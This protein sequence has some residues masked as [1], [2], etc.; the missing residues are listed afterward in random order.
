LCF[1]LRCLDKAKLIAL[2]M[3]DQALGQRGGNERAQG[4]HTSPAWYFGLS[5]LTAGPRHLWPLWPLYYFFFF[6]PF[7]LSFFL[8][9]LA[10]ILTSFQ[11][12][13]W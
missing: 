8:P 9:F 11:A 7:F 2:D 1:F 13:D 4:Q 10:I 3:Q 6:L 5:R 12:E